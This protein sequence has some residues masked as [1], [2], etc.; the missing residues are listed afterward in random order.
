M[1]LKKAKS[2][3]LAIS[4]SFEVEKLQETVKKMAQFVYNLGCSGERIRC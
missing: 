4:M 2:A 3:I 1:R